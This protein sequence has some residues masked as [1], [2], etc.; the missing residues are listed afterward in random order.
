MK[1]LI[2]EMRFKTIRK[3]RTTM[4][5]YF[6]S[7]RLSKIQKWTQYVGEAMGKES[8]S[9]SAAGDVNCYNGGQF[10]NIY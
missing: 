9:Y 5:Y 7:I 4:R 10:G 1:P 3:K 8:V 2:R 6:S